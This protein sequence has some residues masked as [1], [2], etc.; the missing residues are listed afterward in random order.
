MNDQ[1]IFHALVAP[2]ELRATLGRAPLRSAEGLRH[3]RQP[4]D[5]GQARPGRFESGR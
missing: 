1:R 2:G 4:V 3:P 5:R